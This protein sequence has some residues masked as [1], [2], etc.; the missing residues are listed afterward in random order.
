MIGK[1]KVEVQ[2]MRGKT[3]LSLGWILRELGIGRST[4]YVG[5]VGGNL[6]RRVLCI[7]RSP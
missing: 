5:R 4:Y 2:R 6:R 3:G 7:R 1:V